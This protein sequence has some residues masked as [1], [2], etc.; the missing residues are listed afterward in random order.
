MR[1]AIGLL[2]LLAGALVAGAGDLS[3]QDQCW[4]CHTVFDPGG[5]GGGS[6]CKSAIP[7][8]VTGCLVGCSGSEC[9]CITWGD[10]C[11]FAWNLQ[12]TPSGE[13]E[14]LRDVPGD[15]VA[16]ASVRVE[17]ESGEILAGPM[18]IALS[19]SQGALDAVHTSDP[20]RRVR[21]RPAAG[22]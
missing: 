15:V 19:A 21:R 8:G 17:C 10:H 18:P 12:I 2:A 14:L 5:G 3:A 9:D 22:F 6:Y 13:P 7:G 16:V 20:L 11:S 4:I 1:S